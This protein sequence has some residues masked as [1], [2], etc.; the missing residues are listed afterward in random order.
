MPTISKPVLTIGPVDENRR[1]P[2]TVQYQ[3]C[4]STCEALAGS[5][6][7]ER[8]RLKGADPLFDNGLMTLRNACIRA[9]A[10][11]VERRIGA[12]VART[13]L[14][15][16]DD[17][18]DERDEVYAEITLTPFTPKGVSDESAQVKGYFGP[19]N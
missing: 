3:L 10:G 5:V 1:R 19:E 8:V 16:D 4:F 15:E 7:T 2:V 13:V 9:S 14:D 18:W 17:S 12:Q 6:F 11:C